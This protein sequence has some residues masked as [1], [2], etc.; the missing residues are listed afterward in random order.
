M[1]EHDSETGLLGDT[2]SRVFTDQCGPEVRRD[3]ERDGWSPALWKV[4]D[5]G[6]LAW[7]GVPPVAGGSGGGPE[8]VFTLLRQAGRHAVPLPLAECSLLGGWL[9]FRGGLPLPGGPISVAVPRKLDELRL[10]R[11]RIS[12][13]L[14]RVPWGGHSSGV[15]AL[16][17]SSEGIR[18][19]MLDPSVATVTP[20]W[21]MAGEPR[22]V[23]RWTESPLALEHVGAAGGE[24]PDELALRGALSRAVLMSGAMESIRDMTVQYAS[25]RRQFGRPIASF[26]AVAQRLVRLSAETDAAL[27]T[28]EVATRRFA[29]VGMGASFEVAVA[30]VTS[31]RAGSEVA[32]HAD[33]V[34]GAIGM[35]QEYPM[36]HFTRRLWCWRQEW[37][38]RKRWARRLGHR[39]LEA[40]P[41]DLWP[42]LT[43]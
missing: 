14:N 7:V 28:S 9:A 19:V 1:S 30:K 26:Q 25:E 22:D 37:G 20:G 31:G 18:V 42:R 11:G 3:A 35:T 27:L 33:Q 8:E 34:H 24:L 32:T 16:A 29:E 23:L 17:N 40:G 39:V 43:T 6:G 36:H 38:S 4:L 5:E 10:E 21:N 15:V 13:V 2:L 12:G 41:A